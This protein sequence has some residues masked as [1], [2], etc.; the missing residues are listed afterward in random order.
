MV[1]KGRIKIGQERRVDGTYERLV[2]RVVRKMVRLG[3]I[4]Y[5]QFG[6]LDFLILLR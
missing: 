5:A 2:F 3:K 1:W 4:R 6:M